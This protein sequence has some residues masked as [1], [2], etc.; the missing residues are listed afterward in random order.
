M[1]IFNP[2]QT[3]TYTDTTALPGHSYYYV[4]LTKRSLSHDIITLKKGGNVTA[5][6]ATVSVPAETV[7][8]IR[9][10]A[11]RRDIDLEWKKNQNAHT[12]GIYR[13]TSPISR[14][15]ELV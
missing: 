3:G 8:S 9:V 11:G 5:Y 10:S 15:E 2:A 1:G 6:A 13:S 14:I 12:Y 7:K 4:V